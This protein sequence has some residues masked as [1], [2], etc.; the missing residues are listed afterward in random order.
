MIWQYSPYFISFVAC[1]FILAIL[2]ITGWRNRS[3]VCARPFTLLMS[4][5]SLWSF[6]TAIEL[7][8]ADLET[9]MLALTVGYVGMVIVPVAWLLFA[10]EYTGREHL[11]TRSIIV[12]LCAI[13]VLSVIL[14]ATNSDHY[15]FFTT[16]SE[17]VNDSLSFKVVTYGYAFWLYCI[18][19]YLL[20]YVA[21]MMVLQ[22]FVF[23]S[24][25][26]RSQMVIILT[27]A[28]I[29]FFV[30]L[31]FV[32]RQG[33]LALI[34]PTPFAFVI[35]GF[36]ILVGMIRYQLLDVT[37]IPQDQII[38]NMSDGMVVVDLQG[39]IISLN[40]RAERVFGVS[41]KKAIGTTITDIFP[42]SLTLAD[43]AAPVQGPAEKL[44]EIER[45]NDGN[46]Q[47]FELRCIPVF[48]RKTDLKG[49]L[50]MI[51]DITEQ[52]VAGLALVL[53]K[54]KLGLLSSITR[55]DILNQVTVLLL[56]I[57]NACEET[58]DPEVKEWLHRQEAAVQNIQHQIE[59]A[60]DYESLGGKAPRWMN[61]NE[62]FSHLLT[63]MGT[64]NITFVPP[65]HDV[66]VYADPLLERVFYNLVDNSIR[67]G[68]HVTTIS[69]HYKV[70]GID[71]TI[72]YTDN[73]VGVPESDKQKIFRRGVGKHTGLGLFLVKEILEIT[74]LTIR[75]TGTFGSGA[76]FEI[77]V[78]EKKFRYVK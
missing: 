55:H 5:A 11:I 50:I 51:R 36:L 54:K 49:R 47:Y 61:I 59:F 15:L 32:L 34:D 58:T 26:Y 57:D 68:E 21:I 2:A 53:A 20:I 25:L 30:N 71:L 77:H 33:T 56:S 69:I 52:K 14:V 23:T 76:R 1:G 6:C 19:A 44:L 62:I 48:S 4:A 37:P 31:A 67:H 28:L 38:E 35:S 42:S 17:I 13:P 41:R 60:R 63:V 43:L 70:S 16:V 40:S 45:E 29:P 65:D 73:G 24:T 78:P 27:A 10:F 64:V 3:Y 12:F 7:A 8:S 39:R 74:G 9:Q 46:S 72:V 66:D 22:R 75:E 18:Y